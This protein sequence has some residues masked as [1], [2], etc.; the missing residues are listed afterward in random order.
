MVPLPEVTLAAEDNSLRWYRRY[1]LRQN[2]Y[3]A[4][5][6]M[7]NPF[8]TWCSWRSGFCPPYQE[9]AGL[10]WSR[11]S[12]DWICLL[13]H[14][15]AD[16]IRAVLRVAFSLQAAVRGDHEITPVYQLLATG[17][18]HLISV[19]LQI[20]TIFCKQNIIAPKRQRSAYGAATTMVEFEVLLKHD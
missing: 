8:T 9:N 1:I 17:G 3:H 13:A 20:F 10:P 6:D 5:M 2:Q 7:A 15:Q 16:W 12:R 11:Y 4:L 18:E 14:T 19:W